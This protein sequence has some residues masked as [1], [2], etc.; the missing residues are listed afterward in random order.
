M[1]CPTENAVTNPT[2][3]HLPTS[4]EVTIPTSFVGKV[5]VYT[6]DL[7]RIRLLGPD[8]W[9][10]S[11]AFGADGSGGVVISPP[12]RLSSEP[13]GLWPASLPA[14]SSVE[15]IEGSETG[16][17]MGC[18][19]GQACRLFA[20][21]ARLNAAFGKCPTRPPSETVERIDHGVVAFEDPAGVAGDA[22][23]SGGQYPADGVMTFYPN[24]S[25]GSWLDTCTLPP[26]D[27]ALCTT[28]LNVFVSWYGSD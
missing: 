4:M 25:S 21:A 13:G 16:A 12:G 20:D 7:G 3:G 26:A 27:H 11:A 28:S 23:P 22:A 9:E 18:A 10:C 5:A 24:S 14:G 17:C 1:S 8:G 15:T 2:T 19:E 6:D